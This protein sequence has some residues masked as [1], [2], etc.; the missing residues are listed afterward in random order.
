MRSSLPIRAEREATRGEIH[1]SDFFG[2]R[3][4]TGTDQFQSH[5]IAVPLRLDRRRLEAIELAQHGGGRLVR[6]QPDRNAGSLPGGALEPDLARVCLG[7]RTDDRQTETGTRRSISQRIAVLIERLEC[8]TSRRVVHADAII[9]DHQQATGR[10][11]IDRIE[12]FPGR[13]RGSL[14]LRAQAHLDAPAL[15]G[16]LQRVRE[17]GLHDL[18]DSHRVDPG[19]R[20]GIEFDV[21][22]PTG[23]DRRVRHVLDRRRE[24]AGQRD[25]LSFE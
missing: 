13:R 11:Q 7:E 18:H 17:Q 21:H 24:R 10:R 9:L 3:F 22:R 23:P 19:A 12:E 2:G 15:R 5:T 16:E 8:T 4:R 20:S 14:D 1:G 25:L 6:R